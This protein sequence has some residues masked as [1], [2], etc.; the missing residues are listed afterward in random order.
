MFKGELLATRKVNSS[1]G[2]ATVRY[3]SPF[4]I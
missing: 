4:L 2:E 1:V 3:F